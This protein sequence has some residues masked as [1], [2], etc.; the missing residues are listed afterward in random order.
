[1]CLLHSFDLPKIISGFEGLTSQ[2]GGPPQAPA[3]NYAA[4]AQPYGYGAPAPAPGGYPAAQ[5]PPYG[6]PPPQGYP[7]PGAVGG[8]P[9]PA[10]AASYGHVPAQ[11]G[12]PRKSAMC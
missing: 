8:A 5:Q 4:P 6:A 2:P 1:M 7:G 3:Q 12:M 9:P 10:A 11:Q